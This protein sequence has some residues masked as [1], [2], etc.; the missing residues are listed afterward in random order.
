MI[1]IQMREP[2]LSHLD[3]D[4]TTLDVKPLISYNDE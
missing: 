2:G 4:H 1:G 3:A